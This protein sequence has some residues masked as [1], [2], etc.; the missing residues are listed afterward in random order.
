MVGEYTHP[1]KNCLNVPRNSEGHLAK[2]AADVQHLLSFRLPL[3][4]PKRM[5]NLNR[6]QEG[7]RRPRIFLGQGVRHRVCGQRRQFRH[8]AACQRQRPGF[9]S[10]HGLGKFRMP[11][12]P[13]VERQ[14]RNPRRL[15]R[16]PQ[17]APAPQRLDRQKLC[18]R[19]RDDSFISIVIC[20]A[21]CWSGAVSLPVPV[22]RTVGLHIVS[23]LQRLFL[24]YFLIHTFHLSQ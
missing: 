18:R 8:P 4:C 7:D 6:P 3:G 13:F 15:G 22:R 12:P 14:A 10:L 20:S 17:G 5:E 19:Q 11:R 21:I 9:P 1:T 2:S 23:A 16:L 24:K